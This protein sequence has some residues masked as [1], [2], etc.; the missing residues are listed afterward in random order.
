MTHSMGT[1]IKR[2]SPDLESLRMENGGP[3]LLLEERGLIGVMRG[4]EFVN[5]TE[6]YIGSQNSL[7]LNQSY[8]HTFQCN[9]ESDLLVFF[10]KGD[11]Q[12]K[13]SCVGENLNNLLGASKKLIGDVIVR[14]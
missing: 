4:P 11:A 8:T 6:I 14:L 2:S 1:Q 3:A 10:S 9:Y 12:V 7:V 5:E 13:D